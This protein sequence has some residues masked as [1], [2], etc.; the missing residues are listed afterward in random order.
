MNDGIAGPVT[1]LLALLCVQP[2]ML[3][4]QTGGGGKLP[5]R[6]GR[7]IFK[8]ACSA[9]HGPTATGMPQTTI[10]FEAPKTFPIFNRCDQTTPE[11]NVSWKAVILEG[12]P[13]RGFSPIMP[14]F[15]EALTMEQ[16][17]AVI[18][19]LRGLC[20]DKAWPR[21]ELNLPR[22]LVTEKAFPENEA[23]FTTSV[24]A[25]GNP[26]ASGAMVYEQRFGARNM[27]EVLIPFSADRPQPRRWYGGVGDFVFG[28]KRVLFSDLR[29]GSLFSAQGEVIAATGNRA[30]GFGKGVTVFE[31]FASYGQLLPANFFLHA[32]SGIELPRNTEV[33]PRAVYWRTVLG[34]SLRQGGG[35]GRMWSPMTELLADR[36]LETG[37]PINWDVAPQFQVTLSRRQHVRANFGVRVPA[38]NTAGRPVQ[39]MFYLMWDWF[40]GGLREGWR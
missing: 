37:A 29:S 7:E 27:L 1:I 21:G 28:Y 5:L 2:A 4:G 26:G 16:I 15:R 20:T 23:V 39:L 36:D 6:T 8:A 22:P 38:S 24:N 14:S 17:D 3:D 25:R 40:D 34:K 33:A 35:L 9:C 30:R 11:L 18:E 19:Y 13:A 12:G 32:Q 10:G 31:T